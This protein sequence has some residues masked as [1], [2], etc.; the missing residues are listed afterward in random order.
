MRDAVVEKAVELA[1]GPAELARALGIRSQ[2]ISQWQRVPIVRVRQ[3]ERI[4]GI[5]RHELR[6]DIYDAPDSPK[7][8]A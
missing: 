3:V 5:P 6:P 7:A 2:A 4:S 8:A 1:G